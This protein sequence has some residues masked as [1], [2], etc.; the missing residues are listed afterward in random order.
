MFCK[1]VRK[2]PIHYCHNYE[3]TSV[4]KATSMVTT[5]SLTVKFAS[6]SSYQQCSN[7]EVQL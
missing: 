1:S 2:E 7:N 6:G 3:A 5:K 4:Y